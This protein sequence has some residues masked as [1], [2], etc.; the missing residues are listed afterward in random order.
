M[1]QAAWTRDGRPVDAASIPG[2]EWEALKAAAQLGDF[3][4][5]C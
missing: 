2:A 3:M 4:M 5:P 1:T